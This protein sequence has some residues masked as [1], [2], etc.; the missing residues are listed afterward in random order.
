MLDKLNSIEARYEDLL[1]ALGT[2]AVQSDATQY[3]TNAK[4]LAEIEP[5]VERFR[6]YKS[7]TS[8]IAQA[9][10]LAKTDDAEMRAL[11]LEELPPLKARAEILIA[12]IKALLVPKDPN[13]AKNVVLEIRAGTGGDEAALF[14]AE[15]FRMYSRF[16]E[17]QGWRIEVLSTSENGIGGTKEVVASIE[18]KLVYSR[19]KYESGVHRV[20]RVPAT[21]AS[22]RIH[23]ST[24][25]VAVLPEAEEVDVAIEAKDLRVD[26]FC[27]SGPGGQ[28]VNTTY[29][30]VRITHL[31]S[32][33]VVSQQDEKSQV[34]NRSKAMKVLRARL[35]EMEMRKQQAAI[36]KDRRSQVGTG[37]RSEK[38]RTYNYPQSRITD[39][40][41]NFT[42]HRLTDVL[43]GNVTELIDQVVTYYTAEQ[44]KDVTTVGE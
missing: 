3:R 34:K 23:T 22:G 16:A 9:E 20:Q 1:V 37:E 24:A 19:L 2:P 35:Y 12:E 15:L 30:A 18:G 17:R 27:S 33:L 26:T 31:P 13:D 44:L 10:E 6:E 41:I 39:H 5:V 43:D 25:T 32:G 29:S 11:A 40:R 8:Q 7:V 21:E 28:S 36:A 38:I 4:A 14:A 42:T